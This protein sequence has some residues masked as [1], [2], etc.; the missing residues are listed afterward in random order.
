MKNQERQLAKELY[1]RGKNQK[2]VAAATGVQEK[3]VGSWVK[4]YGWKTEREARINSDGGRIEALKNIIGKLSEQRL[5]ALDQVKIEKDPDKILELSRR[6]YT[7]S[8]E[9]ANY[10]KALE[11]LQDQK[12]VS[13][14]IYIEVME[15]I[16]T[17]LQ[18]EHPKL[19]LQLL[20]FQEKHLSTVAIKYQ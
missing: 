5:E 20:D 17:A 11:S 15:Q 16:F 6:G 14:A 12:R 1:M 9:V 18:S 3:T 13:L 4:K 8:N 7:L 10:N 19:Y 2:E